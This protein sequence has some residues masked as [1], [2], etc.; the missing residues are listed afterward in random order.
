MAIV[1]VNKD[2]RQRT[3]T[4]DVRDGWTTRDSFVVVVDDPVNDTAV[5]IARADGVPY[6]WQQH[7][8][9]P[10]LFALNVDAVQ[11]PGSMVVWDVTV[12]YG[13]AA[14]LLLNPLLQPIVQSWGYVK[15]Q[16]PMIRDVNGVPLANSAGVPFDPPVLRDVTR[17]AL[18]VT[19]NEPDFKIAEFVPF[20]DTVNNGPFFG[21]APGQAKFIG[22]TG[23][24]PNR[25]NGV[26]YWVVTYEFHFRAEPWHTRQILDQG[27]MELVPP[28]ITNT[29]EW[30][31][32]PITQKYA[33]KQG[34]TIPGAA[35]SPSNV[36]DI[37]INDPVW[38]NG[39]GR[40]LP[41]RDAQTG[42]LNQPFYLTVQPYRTKNFHQFPFGSLEEPFP[43]QTGN[44]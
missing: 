12:D 29:T 10:F 17:P 27:L 8:D 23:D 19:R 20:Y 15:T 36:T 14:D 33:R 11:R 32:R 5:E 22:V 40:V 28:D 25:Q 1:S 37:P 16:E 18:M 4:W 44:P 35:N 43:Y 30:H 42:E 21:A 7:P 6:L 39:A 31:H 13:F 2:D 3:A 26:R 41:I 38:L 9:F 34:H 24:G